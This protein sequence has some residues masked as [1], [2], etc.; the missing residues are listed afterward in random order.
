M[1]TTSTAELHQQVSAQLVRSERELKE[2]RALNRKVDRVKRKTAAEERKL[3]QSLR[4]LNPPADEDAGASP[5]SQS[6]L[7]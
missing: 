4:K 1:R 7:G 6:T 2:L 5:A 3:R